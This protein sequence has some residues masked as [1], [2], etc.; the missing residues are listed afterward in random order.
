MKEE[1]NNEQIILQAAEEEFL[2]KGYA[3]AKTMEIA[4][5][6]GV[7]HAMLH[8]YFR[9][10]ENLFNKVY[11]SKI[12]LLKESIFILL[13]D[14]PAT[15]VERL[16]S[17]IEGHFD[18]LRANPKL[19]LFII[20]EMISK[21]ERMELL[22]ESIG[23]VAQEVFG[24]LQQQLDEAHQKGLIKEIKATDLLIDVISLN[25]FVFVVYPLAQSIVL[26]MYSS[27]DEFFEARKQ[28]SVRTIFARLGIDASMV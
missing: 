23:R 25:A 26:P 10:K 13:H 27:E 28:E 24:P 17:G 4:K 7:T 15:F 5:K 12:V 19:P 3:A 2:I 1:K 22:K 8:Y 9:T 14:H 18:F 20:N 6:A 21:P 11:E 16:R